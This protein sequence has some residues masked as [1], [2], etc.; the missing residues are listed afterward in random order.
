MSKQI[1]NLNTSL[2]RI[3]RISDQIEHESSKRGTL[4][5][6]IQDS[7]E[8]IDRIKTLII[9]AQHSVDNLKT[10]YSVEFPKLEQTQALKVKTEAEIKSTIHP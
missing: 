9:A 1:A 3:K 10:E 8:K 5:P 2:S 7:K 6:Q 4:L